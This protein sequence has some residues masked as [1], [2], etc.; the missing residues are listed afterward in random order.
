[1]YAYIYLFT[2][3]QFNKFLYGLSLLKACVLLPDESEVGAIGSKHSGQKNQRKF[4]PIEPLILKCQA[5][6][7]LFQA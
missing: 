7:W 4:D 2:H 1:M 6:G 5:M 3:D